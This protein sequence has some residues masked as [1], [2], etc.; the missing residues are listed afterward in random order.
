MLQ[1]KIYNIK[2][3]YCY[4]S[5]FNSKKQNIILLI[6]KIVASNENANNKLIY[7][8]KIH[9]IRKQTG[10]NKFGSTDLEK[11]ASRTITFGI[12]YSCSMIEN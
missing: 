6:F 8:G 1:N 3:Q 2:D 7:F 4:E 10:L 11:P 12:N 5:N 9:F